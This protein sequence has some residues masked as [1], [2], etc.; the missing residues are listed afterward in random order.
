MLNGQ[1]TQVGIP[2][3]GIMAYRPWDAN[4]HTP[5]D[6]R[7]VSVIFPFDA[8]AGRPPEAVAVLC[9]GQRVTYRVLDAHRLADQLRVLGIGPSRRWFQVHLWLGLAA[10]A[11]FVFIGFSGSQRAFGEKVVES[12]NSMTATH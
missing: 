2:S 6:G 1:L 4:G 12:L 3:E 7:L 5:G 11:M 9:G 10:G 8:Q